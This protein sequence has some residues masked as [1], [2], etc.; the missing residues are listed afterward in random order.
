[1]TGGETGRS[2]IPDRMIRELLEICNFVFYEEVS[3]WGKST[4]LRHSWLKLWLVETTKC[5]KIIQC[6]GVVPPHAPPY[7]SIK[8][9]CK[10]FRRKGYVL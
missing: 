9:C 6:E 5:Y 7:V 3:I 10:E 1:M 8:I 2:D 4:G